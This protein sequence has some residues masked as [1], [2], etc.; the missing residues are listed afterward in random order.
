MCLVPHKDFQHLSTHVHV[1]VTAVDSPLGISCCIYI[2]NYIRCIN[3]T[4]CHLVLAH[5]KKYI[6][7]WKLQDNIIRES[8]VLFSVIRKNLLH[9]SSLTSV[10]KREIFSLS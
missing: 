5:T 7:N 4:T 2:C 9:I 8:P 10:N 6:R 1:N 3:C